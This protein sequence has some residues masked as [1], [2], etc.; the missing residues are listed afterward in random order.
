MRISCLFYGGWRQKWQAHSS[1]ILAFLLLGG[2]PCN[3][4]RNRANAGNTDS[5]A[6]KVWPKF[7]CRVGCVGRVYGLCSIEEIASGLMNDKLKEAPVCQC[8]ALTTI[9]FKRPHGG[10]RVSDTREYDSHHLRAGKLYFCEES[11]DR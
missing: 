6:E 2:V 1:L 9:K 8:D 11:A 7:F 5:L 3:G 10:N 4:R